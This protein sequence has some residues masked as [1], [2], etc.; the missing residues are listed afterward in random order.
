MPQSE[1]QL[2]TE[3]VSGLEYPSESDA[4]FDVFA[5]EAKPGA[6]AEQLVSARAK[7]GETIEQISLDEFFTPLNDTDDSNRFRHLRQ[8]LASQLP[9]VKIF[10]VNHGG[11]EV[12]FYL[13]GQTHSGDWIGLHAVAVE[14]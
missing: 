13:V 1:L 14:T 4:P 7:H 10:R 8:T 6:K 11:I 2:L 9:N 5:W 12:H 3:A